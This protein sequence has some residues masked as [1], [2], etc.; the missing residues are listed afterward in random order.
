MAPAP[1]A[2]RRKTNGACGSSDDGRRFLPFLLLYCF[3]PHS[4]TTTIGPVSRP[5]RRLTHPFQRIQRAQTTTWCR[6]WSM[7]KAFC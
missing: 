6:A 4:D 2:G 1:M 5:Q 3:Y 7:A